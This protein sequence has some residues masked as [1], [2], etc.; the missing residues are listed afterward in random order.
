[1]LRPLLFVEELR[2]FDRQGHG[3]GVALHVLRA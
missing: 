3:P 1:M 2:I